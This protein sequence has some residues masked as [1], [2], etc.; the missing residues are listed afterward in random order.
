MSLKES[1]LFALEHSPSL[2]EEKQREQIGD[3][4]YQSS[5]AKLLP[6]FDLDS[7]HGVGASHPP[8]SL[9]A[10]QPW[11][12]YLSA[13]ITENLYDNGETLTNIKINRLGRDAARL[14]RVKVRDGLVMDVT[15]EFFH[16]SLD[17]K[18]IEVQ[19]QQRDLV[20]KQ[21][22][23]VNSQFEQ[24]FKTKSD[25]LRFRAQAQKAELDYRSSVLDA[26]KSE[27]NLKNLV[28]APTTSFATTEIGFEAI[29][30]E[31]LDLRAPTAPPPL[32][33]TYEVRIAKLQNE[34]KPLQ[35]NLAERKLWPEIDVTTGISYTNANYLG[36]QGNPGA[37][38]GP[39]E[40]YSGTFLVEL[41]YNVFD[42]GIR[43]YDLETARANQ[44][45][46]D[47]EQRKTELSTQA[48]IQSLMLQIGQLKDNYN[49][50]KDLLDSEVQSYNFVKRDYD[51]GKVAPYD[52]ILAQN[53]VLSA[54]QSF[55][56]AQYDL[57]EA[58]ARYHYYSGDLYATLS[59]P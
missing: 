35:T 32:D 27:V 43:K 15:A 45:I 33:G 51:E 34:Q 2:A 31:G 13:G 12:S 49:L 26:Q 7:K 8:Y 25:Y 9:S 55:Y 24:G 48:T 50:T 58:I 5:K 19:I 10:T 16:Y 17:K 18:L 29:D 59:L 41:K 3:F 6:S 20:D 47:N 30:P 1:L 38:W 39:N 36:N 28:G 21:F 23:S 52:L 37:G 46:Q 56:H 4:T 40:N 44:V 57:A 14:T 42:W 54:K 22:K 53:D 11:I